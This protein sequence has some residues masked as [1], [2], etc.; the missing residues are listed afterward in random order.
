MLAHRLASSSLALQGMFFLPFVVG[1]V[2]AGGA[3]VSVGM[4]CGQSVPVW[5]GWLIV[6]GVVGVLV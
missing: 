3:L 5:A 4:P 1:V 6:C 2:L